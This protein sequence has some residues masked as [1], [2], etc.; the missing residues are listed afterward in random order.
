[1]KLLKKIRKIATLYEP[2]TGSAVIRLRFPCTIE[3][4]REISILTDFV[5]AKDKTYATVEKTLDNLLK[6]KNYGYS[7]GESLRIWG[8]TEYLIE[9]HRKKIGVLPCVG[10]TYL[11]YQEKG[12]IY[13]DMLGGNSL[14]A[15]EPGLGKTIQALGWVQLRKRLPVLII[16]TASMKEKWAEEANKWTD[17]GDSYVL[18]GAKLKKVPDVPI[19]IVNYDLLRYHV[20][21]LQSKAFQT[22]IIDECHKIKN[23]TAQRTKACMKIV[24]FIPHHILLSGTP[25]E[26]APAELYTSI[27]ILKPQLFPSKYKYLHRYCNP[28]HNGFAWTFD[29]GTNTEELYE[30]LCANLMIRRKKKDELKNL[31]EKT[32]TFIPL[33]LTN[34]KEYDLCEK[35]FLTY[36]RNQVEEELVQSIS[37]NLKEEYQRLITIDEEQLE[38]LKKVR[39]EKASPLSQIEALK[40]LCVKGKMEAVIRWIE[41][42]LESGEKLIVFCEHIFVVDALMESFKKV[43]VKID[44][45]VHPKKRKDIVDRFQN[46]K[47]IRLFIGNEAA[48]EGITL[49]AA[50]NVAIVEF[51]WVPSDLDQRVDRAHRIGQK[52]AVMVWYLGTRNTI[53]EKIVRLLDRRRKLVNSVI[54]GKG[55]KS[56]DLIGELIGL[57]TKGLTGFKK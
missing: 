7:I 31:P 18:Y 42:F 25:I 4:I 6:L 32:Y 16:T 45:S 55:T 54:E 17:V 3:N 35:D 57:Y 52:N 50:S 13:T 48:Q 36:V 8:N 19:Y 15:D 46:D 20:A 34:Q 14:I 53:E 39:E 56:K 23:E 43:A 21:F 22:V 24:R 11:P 12:I 38:Y 44:G 40:Q 51:P 33:P 28:K 47:K 1:M 9:K 30:L 29:G 27:K 37:S 49:T 26:K 10:G 2:P 5:L 41:D